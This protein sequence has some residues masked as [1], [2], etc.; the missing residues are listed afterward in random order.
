MTTLLI[1]AEARP[2]HVADIEES[3]ARVFEAL[4]ESRPEG[5][6]Y[7][8]LRQ[9][10]GVTYV[11]LLAWPDGGPNPLQSVPEYQAFAK[12]LRE[13]LVAPGAT[14]KL[15]TLGSYNLF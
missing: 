5:L 9:D 12:G 1:R 11:I 8:S 6:Q 10:D 4:E 3:A 14:E 13:W 15:S 7:A 2:E